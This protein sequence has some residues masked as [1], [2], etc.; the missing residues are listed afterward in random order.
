MV[1]AHEVEVA[2]AIH[3]PEGDAVR[4]VHGSRGPGGGGGEDT[5][6]VEALRVVLAVA[7]AHEVEIAIAVH[8]PEGDA[9]RP[10]APRGPNGG[11]PSGSGSEDNA[12]IEVELGLADVP[13]HEVEV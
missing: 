8:V 5:A 10:R 9:V 11:G 4:V 2:I 6:L 1:P 12:L 13:A 3:V 7:P